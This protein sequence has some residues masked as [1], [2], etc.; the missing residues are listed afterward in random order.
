MT[1]RDLWQSIMHY[2]RFDRMPVIHWGGWAE[3][4]QRWIS[5]GMPANADEHQFFNTEP[6]WCGMWCNLSIFPTFEEK[7]L[8]ETADYRIVRGGDGVVQQEWKNQSCIPHYIDFTLKTAKDWDQFKA[9]LQ[10]DPARLPA[11]LD[12][13]IANVEK[14]GQAIAIG[15]ASMMGWIRN[16]MGVEN[17]SYLMYD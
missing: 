6:L 1:T 17:M 15:T 3:T 16:W 12:E 14:S 8:E 11:K 10:P 13:A 4:R 5:E 2:G 7:V 9:R